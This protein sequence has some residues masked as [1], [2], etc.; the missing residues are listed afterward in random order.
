MGIGN[1]HSEE[2]WK[3]SKTWFGDPDLQGTWTNASL[4]NLER[5]DFYDTL[6]VSEKQ[7]DEILTIPAH[8]H[9]TPEQI[10]YTVETI[11]SFY[12]S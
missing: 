2:S 7:A 5:P 4:T 11:H 10:E 8:Q 3:N 12:L 6:V 9:V 1:L